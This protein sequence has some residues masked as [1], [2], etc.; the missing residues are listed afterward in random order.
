MIQNYNKEI[1]VNASMPELKSV[2]IEENTALYIDA[3]AQVDH[4]LK[5]L[6][7][8]LKAARQDEEMAVEKT[9]DLRRKVKV[10]YRRIAVVHSWFLDVIW[11][12]LV[13]ILNCIR[14]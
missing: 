5:E 9:R 10:E 13:D 1:I 4:N 3:F 14:T 2:Q 12:Y 7:T 8:R 6:K 11:W